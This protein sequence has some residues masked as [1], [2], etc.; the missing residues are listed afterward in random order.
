MSIGSSQSIFLMEYYPP[1][2]GYIP[3]SDMTK[4]SSFYKIWFTLG[5]ILEM[6][7]VP[8]GFP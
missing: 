4:A 2:L 5:T 1:H 3:I 7:E 8:G 6:R